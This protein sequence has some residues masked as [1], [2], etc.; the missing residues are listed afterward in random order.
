MV[1]DILPGG[2]GRKDPVQLQVFSPIGDQYVVSTWSPL[3]SVG[4]WFW[5]PKVAE[6]ELETTDDSEP[7]DDAKTEAAEDAQEPATP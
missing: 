1:I 6:R 5:P 4:T 7:R 2:E 3:G